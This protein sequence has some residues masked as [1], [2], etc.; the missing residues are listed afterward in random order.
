MYL[1]IVNRGTTAT[2][3]AAAAA[4]QTRGQRGLFYSY[5]VFSLSTSPFAGQVFDLGVLMRVCFHC[6]SLHI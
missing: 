3:A 6:L 2:A 4:G 1:D 5:K